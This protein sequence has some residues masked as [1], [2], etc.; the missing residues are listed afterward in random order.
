[1]HTDSIPFRD[2]G[3]R[4]H[5]GK[6]QDQGKSLST[7]RKIGK[8]GSDGFLCVAFIQTLPQATAS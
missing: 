5:S 8:G 4:G 3:S 2:S 1:M 6:G 7:S